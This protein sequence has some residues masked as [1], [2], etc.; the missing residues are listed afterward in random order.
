MKD[1]V[2]VFF[3]SSGIL[4]ATVQRY[5]GSTVCISKIQSPFE[6]CHQDQSQV[7]EDHHRPLGK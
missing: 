5:A 3:F 7:R 6:D 2:G 4:A 1:E